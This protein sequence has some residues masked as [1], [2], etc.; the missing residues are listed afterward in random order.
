MRGASRVPV[1]VSYHAEI[2]H[3]TSQTTTSQKKHKP[4]HNSRN[5]SNNRA[6][7]T[8]TAMIHT[9][10][11]PAWPQQPWYTQ[12]PY[13]P[14]HNSHDTPNNRTS[15]TTT[16]MIHLTTVPALQ[17]NSHDTP[18]NCISLTTIAI[19][20]QTT[21]PAWP[22][23]IERPTTVWSPLPN[24]GIKRNK[25]TPIPQ[26]AVKVNTSF[27]ERRKTER[28]IYRDAQHCLHCTSYGTKRGLTE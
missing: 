8:K 6:T 14:D 28:N 13:Q 24:A 10:T 21:V 5:T 7:P 23:I 26:E 4:D 11:L 19:I 18:Y 16:G 15:L 12:Q 27:C 20:R 17:K 9:T 2:P 1:L 22:N 3:R 25:L